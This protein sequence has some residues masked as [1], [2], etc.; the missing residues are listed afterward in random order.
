[1]PESFGCDLLETAIDR[2]FEALAE[3]SHDNGVRDETSGLSE[4]LR[5]DLWKRR[6]SLRHRIRKIRILELAANCPFTSS[7]GDIYRLQM[8]LV[9]RVLSLDRFFR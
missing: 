3:G 2:F 1:M 8:L 5:R 9:I 4:I 6:I 7:R